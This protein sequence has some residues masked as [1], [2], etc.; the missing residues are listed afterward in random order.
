MAALKSSTILALS[1][2]LDSKQVSSKCLSVNGSVNEMK[3]NRFGQ[4][5]KSMFFVRHAAIPQNLKI[6]TGRDTEKKFCIIFFGSY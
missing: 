4:K 1:P 6:I 2:Q 5:S 3:N